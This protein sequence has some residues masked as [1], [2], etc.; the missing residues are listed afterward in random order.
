MANPRAPYYQVIYEDT[1]ITEDISDDVISIEYSDSVEGEVDEVVIVVD[2]MFKKWKNEWR[3]RN[4]DTIKLKIGFSSSNTLDCG[5]FYIDK[6]KFRGQP[7]TVEIR[8]LSIA[9]NSGLKQTDSRAYENQSIKE[10]AQEIATEN[11]M[12]L[13]NFFGNHSTQALV[14]YREKVLNTKISRATQDRESYLHFLNRI[15]EKYGVSFTV[16]GDNMYFI[17]RYDMFLVPETQDLYYKGERDES[18]DT[19]SE[20]EEAIISS[21]DLEDN[22]EAITGGVEV[23]YHNDEQ[24]KVYRYKVKTSDQVASYGMN[25]IDFITEKHKAD[26]YHIMRLFEDVGSE[27]EAEMIGDAHWLKVAARKVTGTMSMEGH[28]GLM[29]GIAFKVSGLG[30]LN[31]KYFIK[32]SHHRIDRGGYTTEVEV[33]L[34][35]A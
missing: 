23:V 18:Q 26:E 24:N 20:L 6:I 21:Y 31:G 22:A 4:G 9:S 16:K 17:V 12:T 3:T 14:D 7:D 13:S 1:D 27:R 2:D 5:E 15:G 8:A 10:I 29:A 30:S 19:D 34:I 32:E 25:Q 35:E 33:S 28:V 11:E